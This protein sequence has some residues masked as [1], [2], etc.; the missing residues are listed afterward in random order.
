MFASSLRIFALRE[1]EGECC[2]VQ[3][4]DVAKDTQQIVGKLLQFSL[5]NFN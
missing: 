2:E 4:I 5:T 1:A 3:A